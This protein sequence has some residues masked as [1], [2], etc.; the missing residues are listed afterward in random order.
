LALLSAGLGLLGSSIDD[1]K[2]QQPTV[3][4]K[5]KRVAHRHCRIRNLVRLHIERHGRLGWRI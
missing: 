2:W 1:E 3:N 5:S 4:C